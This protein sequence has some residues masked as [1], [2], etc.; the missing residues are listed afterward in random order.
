M[1]SPHCAH[2]VPPHLFPSSQHS[3]AHFLRLTQC[4]DAH[5]YWPPHHL[6][7][8]VTPLDLIVTERLEK[9]N[10]DDWF[11][12][13]GRH[14]DGLQASALSESVARKALRLFDLCVGAVGVVCPLI[15]CHCLVVRVYLCSNRAAES[16]KAR[17]TAV[18]HRPRAGSACSSASSRLPR[19]PP[20]R[21]CRPPS[22]RPRTLQPP[23][24]P[25][26]VT[27]PG[28][29]GARTASAAGGPTAAAKTSDSPPLRPLRQQPCQR[30]IRTRGAADPRGA[31]G[32]AATASKARR[33]PP[34]HPAAAIRTLSSLHGPG[35][36]A[37]THYLSGTWSSAKM[38]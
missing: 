37:H 28:T 11:K 13:T 23:S 12:V 25:P 32:S 36:N 7:Q 29:V 2:S 38:I 18:V 19:S 8:V 5:A 4:L 33:G 26:P 6:P 31:A 1:F 17:I 16:D 24:R 34:A 3:N 35:S 30:P 10:H 27:A 15:I 21:T 20:A 22:S 14:R 9:K